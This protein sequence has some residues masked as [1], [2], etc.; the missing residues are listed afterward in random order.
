[1]Y[2][3]LYSG[4]VQPF[5][6]LLFISLPIILKWRGKP[7][8]ESEE[9]LTNFSR[10]TTRQLVLKHLVSYFN[11]GSVKSQGFRV[12][13]SFK[14]LNI[15]YRVRVSFRALSPDKKNGFRF[16]KFSKF[17]TAESFRCS[18]FIYLDIL[19]PMLKCCGVNGHTD[20]TYERVPQRVRIYLAP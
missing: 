17:F 1:M 6:W 2:T 14:V 18:K 7:R 20:W 10:N 13:G 5:T 19:Q 12:S 15:K 9:L 16:I 8:C 11:L 3:V 4:F